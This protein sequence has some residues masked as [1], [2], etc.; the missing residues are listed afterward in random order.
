MDFKKYL[1][2]KLKYLKLKDLHGGN[3]EEIV[4]FL[5]S[6]ENATRYYK[7]LF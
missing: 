1:K 3:V 6:L 7:K 4:R 2:Y 5:L